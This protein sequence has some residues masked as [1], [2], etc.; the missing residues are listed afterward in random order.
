MTDER[1]GELEQAAWGGFLL[2]HDRLWRAMERG[3]AGVGL[4]LSEYDVLVALED[5]ADD[6]M[7]LSD[8]AERRGM[9]TGGFT[10]LADRLQQR[11]AIE[12]RRS[13]VDARSSDAVITEAGVQLLGRAREQHL[14]DVRRLFL[15]PLATAD[16]EHL[17][18]TWARLAD[19][20]DDTAPR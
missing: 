7:R 9:T 5:A 13:A 11:G 15:Q 14:A 12:R 19:A 2:T 16:L 10:R 6:G 17:R 1:L 3:L 8:L 4:T 20:G 18:A